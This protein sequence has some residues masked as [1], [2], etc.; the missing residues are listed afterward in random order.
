MAVPEK[1]ISRKR[2]NQRRAHIKLETPGL[3]SC[4]N[5][6]ATI[7]PHRICPECGYYK[8]ILI[9]EVDNY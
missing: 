8:G 7:Q 2:R 3:S 1:K 9:T 4:T 6:G 5:C